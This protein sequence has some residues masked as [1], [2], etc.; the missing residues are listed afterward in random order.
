M[1]RRRSVPHTFD[2]RI[3]ISRE[4]LEAEASSLPDGPER[5]GLREKIRQLEVAAAMNA[6]LS[7]DK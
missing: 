4:R 6:L 1:K 3:A 2:G 7:V 5:D